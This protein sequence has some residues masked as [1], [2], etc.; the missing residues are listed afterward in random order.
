MG[1][2]FPEAQHAGD[3]RVQRV[4]EWL[5]RRSDR[6]IGR[7]ALQWFRGYFAASRNTGCAISI[8]A[9][10]SVVPAALVFVAAVY[11]PGSSVN[12]FAQHLVDHLELTGDTAKLVQGTFGSASSNALAASL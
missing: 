2:S 4:L 5:R 10:L 3:S 8:Y 11:A 12:V 7:L 1:D 9:S 6:P